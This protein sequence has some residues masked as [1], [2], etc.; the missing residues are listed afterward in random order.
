MSE[1]TVSIITNALSFGFGLLCGT[2]TGWALRSLYGERDSAN[3]MK[4]IVG[5]VV[6][7]AWTFAVAADIITQDFEVP[8]FLN[9]SFGVILGALYNVDFTRILRK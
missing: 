6:V 3:V 1:A 9:A 5:G 4:V 7:T 2:T 8:W